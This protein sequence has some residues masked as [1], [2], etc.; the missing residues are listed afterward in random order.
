[1]ILSK[2]LIVIPLF[3]V[4]PA[5]A[6]IQK[7]FKN[8]WILAY[9]VGVRPQKLHLGKFQTLVPRGLTPTTLFFVFIFTTNTFAQTD[10]HPKPNVKLPQFIVGYGSLMETESKR[11][12]NPNVGEN[13]PVLINGYKRGWFVHGALIGFNTTY[14]GVVADKKARFNAT[15]FLL[16]NPQGVS[17]FDKR[18]IGY[19]RQNVSNK[20]IRS[21][22]TQKLPRGQYW[23]YIP[24]QIGL[25]NVKYPLVESHIDIFLTGC[26]ELQKKY[27]LPN[28]AKQCIVTSS[29]WSTHWVNDRIYPRRPFVYQP[30]AMEIDRLLSQQ[31]PQYFSKIKIE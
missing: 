27:H 12:T 25:P 19:C 24:E 10:C 26:L 3:I 29:G 14:L 9:L 31:L 8:Y 17:F 2:L 15:V 4:N 23:I 5:K 22:S 11:K 20:N 1:M 28:F 16:N 21:L 30:N 7:C 18:E 6:G 13:W